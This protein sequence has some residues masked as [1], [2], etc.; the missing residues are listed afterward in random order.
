LKGDPNAL[1]DL[2]VNLIRN[3]ADAS[4][5]RPAPIR[6]GLS[7][8]GNALRLTVQDE[9]HGIL[10]QDVE[11]IFEPG[12]TTKAF[13]EG[14]GMGLVVVQSVARNMFAGSVAVRTT[15]GSGTTMEI[16]LPIPPQRSL[17]PRPGP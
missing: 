4:A 9:G 2:L 11:R 6:V 8:V 3:A 13:G 5:A 14:S 15:V 16:T 12:Y 17:D 7:Q 1:Y 10:P